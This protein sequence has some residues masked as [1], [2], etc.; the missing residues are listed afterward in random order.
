MMIQS[1]VPQRPSHDKMPQ[2]HAADWQRNTS[3]RSMIPAKLLLCIF[4]EITAQHGRPHSCGKHETKDFVFSP[5]RVFLL[6]DCN[7]TRTQNHLV[8]KRTLN[9]LPKWFSVRL[10]SG[11][12]FES[13]CSHLNF[14][15]RVCFSSKEFLD[16]QA[17]I[18]CR[19]TLK[20]VRDMTGT[21]N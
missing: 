6:I 2:K 5:R 1:K 9:H 7:W 3:Y 12:G 18:E 21:N 11:S 16:I 20:R 14:R 10:L 19:F 8:C 4:I 13:T 17:T 15:F